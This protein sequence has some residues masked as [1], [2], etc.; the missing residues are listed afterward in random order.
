MQVG[1]NQRLVGGDEVFGLHFAPRG[2]EEGDGFGPFPPQLMQ[3]PEVALGQPA[4]GIPVG[5]EELSLGD[6]FGR[7]G[8]CSGVERAVDFLPAGQGE[9][10][11]FEIPRGVIRDLARRDLV[12]LERFFRLALAQEDAGHHAGERTEPAG[13]RAKGLP[14]ARRGQHLGTHAFLLLAAQPAEDVEG[15]RIGLFHERHAEEDAQGVVDPVIVIAVGAEGFRVGF[16]LLHEGEFVRA[17]LERSGKVDHGADHGPGGE[18]LTG[19]REV[20][21]VIEQIPAGG[22]VGAFLAEDFG[23]V[24]KDGALDQRGVAD[25]LLGP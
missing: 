9:V 17:E 22:P 11:V 7:L 4:L 1:Q 20:N 25:G 23:H 8:Q 21:M 5:E 15:P 16:I 12:E 14:L 10:D 3:A 6:G 18:G 24:A 19:E 2:E 13:V